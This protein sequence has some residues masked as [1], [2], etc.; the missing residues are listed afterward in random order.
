MSKE[1]IDALVE[2]GKASAGPP[3]GPALG[4]L[5]VKIPDVISEINKKTESF[6]GMKIPVK[7]IVDTETK[8]FEVAVGSPSVTAMIKKE[9]GKD[10]LLKIE[11]GKRLEPGSIPLSTV[12]KIAK[13]K[14]SITGDTTAKVK[15][16]LGTCLS[17]GVTVDGK[18]PKDVIREINEGKIKVE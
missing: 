9:L 12:I 17:A 4:A 16:V 1:K 8:K 6:K 5:K 15:Q 14:A 2:G 18:N 10:K 11:E 13:S 7:V 3:L